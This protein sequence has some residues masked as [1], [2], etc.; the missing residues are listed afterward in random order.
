MRIT[1]ALLPQTDRTALQAAIGEFSTLHLVAV[2][3]SQSGNYPQATT[4]EFH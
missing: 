1:Y 4:D 2:I 3:G